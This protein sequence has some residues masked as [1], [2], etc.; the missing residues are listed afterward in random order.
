M[1][2]ICPIS[3]PCQICARQVRHPA[4]SDT[5]YGAETH[6]RLVEQV[7]PVEFCNALVTAFIDV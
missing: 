4:R 6:E 5:F 7:L 1:L 2:R 3:D